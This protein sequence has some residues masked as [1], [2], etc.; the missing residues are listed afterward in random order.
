MPR[1]KYKEAVGLEAKKGKPEI[2]K[3]PEKAELKKLYVKE[4][5]S[6]REIAEILGCSKDMV[7]RSLQEYR[8]ERRDHRQKRSQLQDYDLSYLK[9]V[10]KQKGFV[11]IAAELGV[12]NTTLR[13]DMERANYQG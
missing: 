11:Q 12:H 6:I 7:Y 13:R 3:R 2:G 5:K 4:S 9:K 1:I 8:I 10:I